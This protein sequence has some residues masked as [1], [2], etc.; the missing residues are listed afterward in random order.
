MRE[1]NLNELLSVID[2]ILTSD[3]NF[4]TYYRDSDVFQSRQIF[5]YLFME[6]CQ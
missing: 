6:E 1:L 3:S 4:D 2:G 5:R